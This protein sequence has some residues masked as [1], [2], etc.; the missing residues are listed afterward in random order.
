MDVFWFHW[1]PWRSMWSLIELNPWI[2]Y[3][4]TMHVKGAVLRLCFA[5]SNEQ[6]SLHHPQVEDIG[7]HRWQRAL[8]RHMAKKQ[9]AMSSRGRPWKEELSRVTTMSL[10]LHY[11]SAWGKLLLSERHKRDN[12]PLEV[13]E[14]LN[15]LVRQRL[16][17]NVCAPK[18]WITSTLV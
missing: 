7:N 15:S 3:D 4:L 12:M 14:K 13:H 10:T 9:R 17:T 5:G 2:G 6:R 1:S 18:N 8:I 16:N 11:S